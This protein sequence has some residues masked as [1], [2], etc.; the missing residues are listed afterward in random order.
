MS[1][2]TDTPAEARPEL[3]LRAHPPSPRRLSRKVLLAGALAAGALVAF[4]L[5]AGLS[6]RPSQFRETQTELQAVGGPPASIAD[7]PP[8]Y[9]ALTLSP[10]QT[11]DEAGAW[12][13]SAFA[14]TPASA[15][16]PPSQA[17]WRDGPA[18]APSPGASSH[19]PASEDPEQTARTAPILFETVETDTNAEAATLPS[20]L[21][22]PQSR[23]VVQAGAVIA[24]ALVTG[25]NSDL[26]GA[27]IAQV[28]QPV[29]DTV[30]GEHLLIPQ[31]ARLIGG[32]DNRV[33][34]GDRRMLL[35]WERLI[36]PN[37]W[38]IDLR[39]MPAADASG[40]AGLEDRTD[41]HLD[42]LAVAIGLSAVLSVIANESEGEE[43]QGS[44]SQSVGDAAAQQAAQ[45]GARIVERE[46]DVR[47]T[48]TVRP[49]APVRVL[50]TRDIVL[51]PYP[52]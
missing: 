8:H 19:V 27:V 44:L 4:A 13:G 14:A 38:S 1:A 26:P 9:E 6:Q 29:Y 31:G 47:P 3:Q 42:R 36:L 52:P 37:G 45:S 20:R 2:P 50:V 21:E 41:N 40:A 35:S 16:A 10:L 33:R 15:P 18:H 43:E 46:L 34:Y 7:A 28:S 32:Y 51:R 24:A 30:T 49:G 48:L 25:L 23:Y 12:E 11:E 39:A 17:L 5:V 22:P